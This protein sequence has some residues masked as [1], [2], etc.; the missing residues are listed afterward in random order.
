MSFGKLGFVSGGRPGSFGEL[1][2]YQVCA[3]ASFPKLI[4][5]SGA[6][7]RS[8]TKLDFVSVPDRVSFPKLDFVSGARA[9]SFAKLDFVSVPDRASFPKLCAVGGRIRLS[10]PK[11]RVVAE[12]VQ[13]SF[14]KLAREGC[15]SAAPGR[16]RTSG[17]CAHADRCRK[18]PRHRPAVR[19]RLPRDGAGLGLATQSA[20]ISSRVSARSTRRLQRANCSSVALTSRSC[21]I[22]GRV[23]NF[24]RIC[25]SRSSTRPSMRPSARPCWINCSAIVTMASSLSGTRVR[26]T[27]LGADRDSVGEYRVEGLG[28]QHPAAP[29]SELLVRRT[30]EP[31]MQR[32]W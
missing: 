32:R 2:L 12:L 4:F 11:L 30:H 25:C 24:S 21:S 15:D 9:R 14:P 27:Q 7:A 29:A 22:G 6:R 5:V 16:E 19:T 20:N 23:P 10:F 3:S 8:F 31:L 18:R 1:D 13:P 17:T 26:G 28:A